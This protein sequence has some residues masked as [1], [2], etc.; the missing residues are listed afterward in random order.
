MLS[1]IPYSGGAAGVVVNLP[2]PEIARGEGGGGGGE[3]GGSEFPSGMV[4]LAGGDVMPNQKYDVQVEILV[5]LSPLNRDLGN[6]MVE[7]DFYSAA[8]LAPPTG[9][10][11][12]PQQRSIQLQ[13][14]LLHH[15]HRPA[16]LTYHSPLPSLLTILLKAP[17]LLTR[18][19]TESELITVPIL[20]R[21]SFPTR[22][23]TP[24]SV[25]VTLK[26]QRIQTYKV[27]V[28]FRARLSGLRNFM[29][30]YR[31][32]AAG[33]FV[34]LFWVIEVVCAVGV[35]WVLV[36][37][38][39]GEGVVGWVNVKREESG[40]SEE[41]TPVE[42]GRVQA[43]PRPSTPGARPRAPGE[44]EIGEREIG[45]RAYLPS[46]SP[47]P[48]PQ[49]QAQQQEM[50]PEP[51]REGY[52]DDEET[53]GS[54]LNGMEGARGLARRGVMVED[55]SME[56]SEEEAVLV[57]GRRGTP[58]GDSG[59]GSSLYESAS[60]TG[61]APGREGGRGSSGS[62]AGSGGMRRR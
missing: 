14:H 35:W 33:V 21:I 53:E 19:S 16:I 6:F 12:T 57:S 7:A 3:G 48:Q 39:R 28:R 17:L 25:R 24:K 54:I 32:I 2:L 37:A 42:A 15:T 5:P 11:G 27:R 9:G 47:T 1:Q 59:V 46:P 20:E 34:G 56:E 43:A 18:L 10:S 38:S 44:R 58:A 13:P 55:D 41:L 49:Q 22:A 31:L 61:V 36:G 29:Y 50:P 62:G 8:A 60:A 45:E 26:A 23:L 30:S 51:V 4:E 40:E 52:A